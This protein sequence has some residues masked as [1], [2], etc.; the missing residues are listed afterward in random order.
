REREDRIVTAAPSRSCVIGDPPLPHLVRRSP[1]ICHR[2]QP[3]ARLNL[4]KREKRD[5]EKREREKT[6]PTPPLTELRRRSTVPFTPRPSSST[7]CHRH[8]PPFIQKHS[9]STNAAQ[10][11]IS[12]AI[13]RSATIVTIN[14]HRRLVVIEDSHCTTR[15]ATFFNFHTVLCPTPASEIIEDVLGYCLVSGTRPPS[16]LQ[17][18]F[19]CS[20]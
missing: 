13:I 16:D 8:K 9:T 20:D 12:T 7:I 4:R 10:P 17:G 2:R 15:S 11:P 6:G 1:R 3:A 18:T 5:R 19:L 14:C